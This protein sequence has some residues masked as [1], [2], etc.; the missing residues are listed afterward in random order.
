MQ[1]WTLQ[2]LTKRYNRQLFRISNYIND[3]N[4]NKKPSLRSKGF[5]I[6]EVDKL[7]VI[8]HF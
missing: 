1:R 8:N 6:K 5:S 7:P 3:S 4:R 2:S